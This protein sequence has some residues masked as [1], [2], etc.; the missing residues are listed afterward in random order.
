[1]ETTILVAGFGGQGI[2]L[3]GQLLGYSATKAGLNATYFPAYGPEQRGGT[4]SCS[5]V[6]SD[7]QIGS[8]IVNMADT[9]IILNEPSLVKFMPRVNSGGTILLNSSLIQLEVQNKDVK[10]IKVPATDIGIK[11]G[12]DKIA[13]MAML[14]AYISVAGIFTEE[15]VKRTIMEKLAKKPEMLEMNLAAFK[16]GLNIGESSR[17]DE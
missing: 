14:G 16:A 1:M 13:N 5:V 7:I 3:L 2:L 15:Q 12:S 6:I 4:A 11:L 10:V 8:P 17:W 9:L